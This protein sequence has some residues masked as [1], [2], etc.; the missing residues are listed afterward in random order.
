M[1]K[2]GECQMIKL[3]ELK[4]ILEPLINE[5]EDASEIIESI[6]NID[7]DVEFDRTQIDAEWNEK[8]KK[9][10]FEK[11]KNLRRQPEE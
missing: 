8:F 6:Q 10:F 11:E 5:R 4:P 7:K 9:A 1:T 3:D 2:K